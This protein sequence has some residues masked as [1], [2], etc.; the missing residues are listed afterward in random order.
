VTLAIHELASNARDHGAFSVP[1]GRVAIS[2][3]MDEE[4]GLLR[5]RWQEAGG[6]P[7][8][9]PAR[10]AVGGKMIRASI[11]SQLR[12]SFSPEW[13]EAGFAA[14]ITLP[15]ICLVHQGA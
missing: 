15:M 7:A 10:W 12:G 14:E 13:G 8:K 4:A 9:A 5:L 11:Q 3:R 2:W 6:P 1:G